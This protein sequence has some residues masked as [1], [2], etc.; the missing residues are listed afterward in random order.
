MYFATTGDAVRRLRAEHQ[1]RL[2]A[3][4]DS[5]WLTA[6][7]LGHLTGVPGR[8]AIRTRGNAQFDPYRACVGIMHAAAAAGANVFERSAVTRIDPGGTASGFTPATAAWTP[9]AS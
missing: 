9:L 2:R 6:A 3:G 4:F 1:L 8:G 5:E 7:A